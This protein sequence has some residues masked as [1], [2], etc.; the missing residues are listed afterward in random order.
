M[1]EEE[2]SNR[3]T[4]GPRPVQQAPLRSTQ[5]E[6]L[7]EGPVTFVF[8]DI[9]GS[10]ALLQRIGDGYPAVLARHH[11]LL[12]DAFSRHAGTEVGTEGDSF[13]VVFGAA[14]QALAARAVAGR[15]RP[16]PRAGRSRAARRLRGLHRGL[17]HEGPL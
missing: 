17:G 13:F 14:P 12:R 8:T 16:R 15:P 2:L 4:M 10:T 9:E 1:L 7:P 6:V 11:E 3:V 5:L